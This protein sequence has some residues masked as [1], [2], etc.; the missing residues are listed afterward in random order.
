MHNNNGISARNEEDSNRI[1]SGEGL[2][3]MEGSSWVT[4]RLDSNEAL[5]LAY[6]IID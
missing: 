1:S 3:S 5:L 4:T 6:S 2:G